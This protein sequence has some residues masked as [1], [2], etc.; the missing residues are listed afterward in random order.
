MSS[1]LL[2]CPFPQLITV[3]LIVKVMLARN[4]LSDRLIVFAT[5]D[6]LIIG[7]P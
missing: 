5:L 6:T 3:L 1:Q 2:V 4:I 7:A